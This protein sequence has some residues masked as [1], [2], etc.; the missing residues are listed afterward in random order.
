MGS[1]VMGMGI[2]LHNHIPTKNKEY[3]TH[4]ECWWGAHFPYLSLEP[5]GG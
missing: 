4:E 1:N 3:H 5:V 2:V